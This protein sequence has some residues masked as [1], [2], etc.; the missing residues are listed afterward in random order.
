MILKVITRKIIQLSKMASCYDTRSEDDVR[1]SADDTSCSET[2][3]IHCDSTKMPWQEDHQ[4]CDGC[5]RV[6]CE[7]CPYYRDS[8]F[9]CSSW[10]C[11][12]CYEKSNFI[13]IFVKEI[14]TCY[15]WQRSHLKRYTPLTIRLGPRPV[16]RIVR[17]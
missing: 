13:P 4:S 2:A 3:C 17:V 1:S 14:K 11:A 12:Q 7:S 16:P 6:Y 5:S 15:S 9:A 8:R 10:V